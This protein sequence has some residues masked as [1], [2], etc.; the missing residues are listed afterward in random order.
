MPIAICGVSEVP[1]YA[2]IP[3]DH[4]ISIKDCSQCGPN[5]AAFRSDF[6]L[7]SFVFDDTGDAA[8]KHAVTESAIRRLLGIYAQT[9][10]EDSILFHCFAGVSRSSAAAFL[11]LVHHGCPYDQAYQL[12]VAI[13][14]PFI[15]PNQ[16]MIK[17]ADDVMGRNGEMAAFMS[18]E[19]GRRAPERDAFFKGQSGGLVTA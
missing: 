9:K 17:L 19:I 4:I 16:L 5:L 15:C 10:P 14:G 11:W 2:S 1:N 18:A 8:A 3:L 13:R 12:I 6:T 7:H